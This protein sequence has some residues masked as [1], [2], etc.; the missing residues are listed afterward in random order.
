MSMM[1][2]RILQ[3]DVMKGLATLPDESVQRKTFN[4]S[5]PHSSSMRDKAYFAGLIDGE[6]T[7]YV[8]KSTYRLRKEKY[9]DR[10]NPTY[11]PTI[12]I[13]MTNK[14]ALEKLK[15]SFGGSLYQEKRI[16]CSVNGF[17]TNK[18]LWSWQVSDN[19][20]IRVCN[21][22]HPFSIIKRPNIENLLELN[23]LRKV[24]AKMRR[25]MAWSR[26]HG[27]PYKPEWIEQFEKCYL[28]SKELNA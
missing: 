24:A 21:A 8:K 20:A 10:V 16:Y 14:A 12:K 15:E 5:H 25:K 28:K 1:L 9:H 3:G 6:A 13:K 4:D 2:H 7:V 11:S 18:L 22:I 26:E 17:K 19:N 23:R 27:Q